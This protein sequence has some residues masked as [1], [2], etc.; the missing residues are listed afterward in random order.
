MTIQIQTNKTI[1]SNNISK[2]KDTNINNFTPPIDTTP[3]EVVP[4]VS[5]FFDNYNILF[6][7]IP[8]TGLN[9]H[10]TLVQ[11]SAEYIGLNLQQLYSQLKDLQ[12]QNNLLQQQIDTFNNGNTN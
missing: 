8:K 7:D 9:S 11:Q 12:I 10:E 3:V 2:V 4:T 6:Y 5:D 1:Y